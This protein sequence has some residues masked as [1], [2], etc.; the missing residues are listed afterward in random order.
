MAHDSL[1]FIQGPLDRV[2]RSS[3]LLFDLTID[4]H[5]SDYHDYNESGMVVH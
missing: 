4:H 5:A 1:T 3:R 2:M